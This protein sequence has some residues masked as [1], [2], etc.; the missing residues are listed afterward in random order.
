MF[1]RII[2]PLDGSHLAEIALIH[3]QALATRF[4][5]PIHLIRVLDIMYRTPYGAYL[6]FEG[7]D[8]T[9]CSNR[10]ARRQRHT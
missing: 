6:S 3:A 4:A 7:T 1:K 2:G 10:N 8:S 9:R 5:T